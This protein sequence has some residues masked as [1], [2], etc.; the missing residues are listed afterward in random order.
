MPNKRGNQNSLD[1][2][3]LLQHISFN[4]LLRRALSILL[5]FYITVC[6]TPLSAQELFDLTPQTSSSQNISHSYRGKGRSRFPT[7]S[8]LVQY[9]G[10][11]K[12][13][14]KYFNSAERKAHRVFYC[15]QQ[16]CD[17]QG[18]PLNSGVEAP[19]NR[20]K[21]FPKL[22]ENQNSRG[23]GLAIYVM[24]ERGDLWVSFDAHP[25]KL[26]HSSLLSGAPVAAA[27]EML[28]FN[29]ILYGINNYSGHYQ[30]PPIVIDR[31]LS[32]LKERGVSTTGLLVKRFGSDF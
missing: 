25:R 2:K 3:V 5:M 8:M 9:R 7:V 23:V 29:G 27:G 15:G 17:L 32:V 10:E 26:H 4:D 18:V 22:K 30:P 31:A 14:V 11:E 24:D 20:P 1:P 6:E 19:L 16:L 28:I 12:R 21:K 13:G